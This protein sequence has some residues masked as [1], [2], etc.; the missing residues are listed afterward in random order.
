[1]ICV[2]HICPRLNL[3]TLAM[4]AMDAELRVAFSSAGCTS[5]ACK[6]QH[7]EVKAVDTAKAKANQAKEKA[8]EAR[9]G[10]P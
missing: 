4:C 3:A 10:D 7:P 2:P 1:M 8:K 5:L 9:R 6:R